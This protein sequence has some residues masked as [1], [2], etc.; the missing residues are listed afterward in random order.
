[1]MFKVKL[2]P[3]SLLKEGISSLRMLPETKETIFQI[4]MPW[5]TEMEEEE[6]KKQK[7]EKKESGMKQKSLLDF[8]SMKKP[9][10]E[11]PRPIAA[12]E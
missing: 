4:I 10:Q 11:T 12:E 3:K 8:M 1:M 6:R 7:L 5:R 9:V 2:H